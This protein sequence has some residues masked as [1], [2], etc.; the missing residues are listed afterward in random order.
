MK[1]VLNIVLV[2]L[3]AIGA[4]NLGIGVL[5]TIEKI[6]KNL[7]IKWVYVYIIMTSIGLVALKEIIF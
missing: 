5:L 2:L 6:A 1:S 7:S 4:L 3:G